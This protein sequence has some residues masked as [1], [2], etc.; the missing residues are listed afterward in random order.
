M[1][2]MNGQLTINNKSFNEI[3][4]LSFAMDEHTH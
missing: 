1:K 3:L 4:T 2:L